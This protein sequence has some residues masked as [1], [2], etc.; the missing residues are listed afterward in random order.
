[1]GQPRA[2]GERTRDGAL[3]LLS[4]ERDLAEVNLLAKAYYTLGL[5]VVGGLDLGDYQPGLVG[6]ID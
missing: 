5:F 2:I 1:M 4:C 3:E 6:E